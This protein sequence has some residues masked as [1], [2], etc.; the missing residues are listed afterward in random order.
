[1]PQ[2]PLPQPQLDRTPI[3]LDQYEAYTPEKLELIHGFYDYGYPDDFK[4]FYL[5]ILTN[6]GLSAAVSHVPI[7]KWLATIQEVALQNPKLDDALRDRLVK[8]IAE[9][10]AVVECLES[11]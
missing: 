10:N 7:S 1:M 2:P 4:G 9:L 11:G 3:T 8:G 5:A 6:M